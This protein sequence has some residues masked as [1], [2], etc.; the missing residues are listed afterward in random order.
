[1][2][3]SQTDLDPPY[4][5]LADLLIK[6]RLVPFLGA[7][8]S[9]REDGEKTGAQPSSESLPSAKE[10]GDLLA[11]ELGI[12]ADE[13]GAHSLLEVASYYELYADR[14]YLQSRLRSIFLHAYRPGSL[15]RFLAGLPDP[16][17]IVTTNYDRLLEQAFLAQNKP[18]HLVVTPIALRECEGKFLWWKRDDDRPA[19]VNPDELDLSLKDASVIFKIHGSVDPNSIE[20]DSFVI[21]EDDYFEMAGRYF[22]RTLIPPCIHG[23][24]VQSSIVFLGYSLR[25]IH[26]RHVVRQTRLGL[27]HFA[28]AKSMSPLESYMWRALK[29]SPYEISIQEFV[30]AMR[31]EGERLGTVNKPPQH[32]DATVH[33]IKAKSKAVKHH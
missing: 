3:Y 25:D 1:M 7:G 21:T 4:A 22:Q 17:L 24:L 15:H 31:A 20:F 13:I 29:I 32:P 23:H 33:K 19:I 16:I 8:A 18:Y 12:D 10:L 26:M 30:Q 14:S 9:L 11:K 2:A 5:V 6:G 28:V 27:R